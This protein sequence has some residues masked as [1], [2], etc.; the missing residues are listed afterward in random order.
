MAASVAAPVG[1]EGHE[2]SVKVPIPGHYAR[3]ANSRVSV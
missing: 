2:I 1:I 3:P